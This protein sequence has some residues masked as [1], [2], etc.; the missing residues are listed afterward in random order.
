MILILPILA[1]LSGCT[2]ITLHDAS[3]N[4]YG[5]CTWK[6]SGGEPDYSDGG[7]T[8]T[9]PSDE[10]EETLDY[11]TCNDG[12]LT[13]SISIDYQWLHY[14]FTSSNAFLVNTPYTIYH[15]CDTVTATGSCVVDLGI[16]C[17]ISGAELF[18][19]DQCVK[20]GSC[21]TA[22]TSDGT[23]Y[24]DPSG[25]CLWSD[26][27]CQQDS[28][29]SLDDSL[30]DLNTGV[31]L[32]GCSPPVYTYT[33]HVNGLSST[34][35]AGCASSTTAK[36]YMPGM[37]KQLVVNSATS[38]ITGTFSSGG[39]G[40]PTLT[41]PLTGSIGVKTTAPK[42]FL[43]GKVWATGGGPIS[44]YVLSNYRA[45]FDGPMTYTTSG[46][47]FTVTPANE[48]P[49]QLAGKGV[50]TPGGT[51]SGWIDTTSNITGHLNATTWDLDWTEVYNS[52]LTVHVHM[53]GTVQ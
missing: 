4:P 51:N 2:C 33:E 53:Q 45:R 30:A 47:S 29:A 22:T 13:S 15:N 18:P 19:S 42:K 48:A 34:C 6:T 32:L 26:Y 39:Y 52:L 40:H 50:S 21:G 37:T 38:Y 9:T 49:G 20:P 27:L 41:V 36:M 28:L 44:A 3:G 24:S 17:E 31:A 5:S 14:C 46:T 12:S 23:N 11:I 1:F 10:V 25:F 43:T 8:T 16:N 7:A 35:T